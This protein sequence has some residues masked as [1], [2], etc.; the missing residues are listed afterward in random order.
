MASEETLTS[1]LDR[2]KETYWAIVIDCLVEIYGLPVGLARKRALVLR[3]RI[4]RLP[5]ADFFYHDEPVNV[6]MDL[7][8]AAASG[9]AGPSSDQREIAAVYEKIRRNYDWNPT[10]RPRAARGSVIRHWPS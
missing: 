1:A 4:S 8:E 2:A 7:A 9:H 10:R 5:R 6:A 3:D